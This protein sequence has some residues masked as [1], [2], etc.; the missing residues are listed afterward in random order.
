MAART[1]LCTASQAWRAGLLADHDSGGLH[2]HLSAAGSGAEPGLG[3]DQE[4]QLPAQP[5]VA[6]GLAILMV[7]LG[8]GS[9]LLNAGARDMLTFVFFHHTDNFVFNRHQLSAGWP[10]PPAWPRSCSSF[11][12]TG[13]CPTARCPGVRCLRTSI[14][15]GIIW[16][17]AKYVFVAVLP[18][19]RS[20]GALR[21]VLCLGGIAVLGLCFGADPVCRSAVQRGALGAKKS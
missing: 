14:V 1:W 5:G 17:V 10:P 8:M 11:P 9:I 12:S 13:C 16:L 7:V 20:G 4:P 15:T 21:A 6:F 18:H 19:L 2:G 3:R